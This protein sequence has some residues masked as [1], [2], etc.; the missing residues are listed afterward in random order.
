MTSEDNKNN[1]DSEG[2]K[3]Q[4]KG[5]LDGGGSIHNQREWGSAIGKAFGEESPTLTG[6]GRRF[7]GRGGKTREGGE[8]LLEI[9]R[10]VSW[11][12]PQRALGTRGFWRGG[13]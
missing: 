11:R 8:A 12:H 13:T 2:K 1:G 7:G 4:K 9:E 5:K 10:R 3:L 6:T